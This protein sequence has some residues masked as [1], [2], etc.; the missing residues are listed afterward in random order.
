MVCGSRSVTVAHVL[1]EQ[2]MTLQRTP[3]RFNKWLT[4]RTKDRRMMVHGK[5]WQARCGPV[6]GRGRSH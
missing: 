5:H 2:Q 4:T 3:D 6:A 1:D